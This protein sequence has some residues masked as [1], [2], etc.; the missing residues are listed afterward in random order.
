MHS[1]VKYPSMTKSEFEKQVR[2]L[3]D[4][5][6]YHKHEDAINAIAS[7]LRQRFID[8]L[9]IGFDLTETLDIINISSKL[10]DKNFFRFLKFQKNRKCLAE[11]EYMQA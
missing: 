5:Y 9:V 1:D 3:T 11:L 4:R 8:T 7:F 6:H 2:D 10:P